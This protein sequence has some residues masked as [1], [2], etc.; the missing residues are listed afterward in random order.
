MTSAPIA[1]IDF[2]FD[3]S[4]PYGYLAAQVIDDIGARHGLDVAWRP[5]LLGAVFKITGAQPLPQTPLKDRYLAIDMPRS[6]R[7]LGVPFVMPEPFPFQSLAA[8]RAYYWLAEDDPARSRAFAKAVFHGSFG[9]GRDM[10]TAEAVIEEAAKLGIDRQAL[11]AALQ[12]P[13]VKERLRREVDAAIERGVYGSPFFFLDDEPFW[14]HDRLD[15]VDRWL[16]TG[17]W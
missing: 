1:S 11:A 6:A 3:F 9:E 5:F 17:G 15:Q 8:C 13:A 2:Y 14:G 10:S 16:E 4:S 7:L 12:H